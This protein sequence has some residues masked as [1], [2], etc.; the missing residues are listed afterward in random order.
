MS[1]NN[2]KKVLFDREV[3]VFAMITTVIVGI[4]A[5]ILAI[6]QGELAIGNSNEEVINNKIIDSNNFLVRQWG[7]NESYYYMYNGKVL[8]ATDVEII[9]HGT[10]APEYVY[11]IKKEEGEFTFSNF[12]SIDDGYI[13]IEPRTSYLKNI[14][15]TKKINSEDEINKYYVKNEER[16]NDKNEI[17]FTNKLGNMKDIR[18]E[19]PQN[20]AFYISINKDHIELYSN[21]NF[22]VK[23]SLDTKNEEK[24]HAKIYNL[25]LTREPVSIFVDRENN[26]SKIENGIKVN[27]V[28]TYRIRGLGEEFDV[29]EGKKV[30]EPPRIKEYEDGN[31]WILDG[32]WRYRIDGGEESYAWDFENDTVHNDITFDGLYRRVD[33]ENFEIR[34]NETE[35]YEYIYENVSK[36]IKVMGSI[37]CYEKAKNTSEESKNLVQLIM[38]DTCEIPNEKGEYIFEKFLLFKD[39][40]V[41]IKTLDTKRDNIL[42]KKEVLENVEENKYYIEGKTTKKS[43]AEDAC[44]V[45]IY[46]N[47]SDVQ[48]IATIVFPKGKGFYIDL[49]EDSIKLSSDDEIKVS[50]TLDTEN[51]ELG[52]HEITLTKEPIILNID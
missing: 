12:E 44:E 6:F 42:V 35:N 21:E 2:E 31:V 19:F 34:M 37:V 27:A 22:D 51:R 46:N 11:K 3:V 26:Y 30:A 5:V 36:K 43:Y 32:E 29:E 33:F 50:V 23:V 39:G 10:T 40:R 49:N 52:N 38:Y 14:A 18:I 28:K 7:F 20:E 24:G 9:S 17:C 13:T 8:E 15:I 47:L 1:E 25:T 48:T 16:R 41:D 45:A 4:F